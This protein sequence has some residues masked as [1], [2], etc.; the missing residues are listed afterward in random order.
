MPDISISDLGNILPSGSSVIPISNG[1]VTGKATIA[2]LQV[3]YSNLTNKPTIPTPGGIPVGTTA[4]RPTSP[5]LGTMRFNTTN[6]ALEWWSGEAWISISR[7]LTPTNRTVITSSTTYNR[8]NSNASEL[9]VTVVGGGG[10]GGSGYCSCPG[11]NGGF[12]GIAYVVIPN[13]GSSYAVTVG[14]G[15]F[16]AQSSGQ[17]YN[18]GVNGGPGGASSFGSIVAGGGAAG[19]RAA[20]YAR[21]ADGSC[22]GPTTTCTTGQAYNISGTLYG[23]SG[24]GG[25]QNSNCEYSNSAQSA[26]SQGVVVVE[27]YVLGITIN[28]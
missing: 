18:T 3:D 5:S 23:N 1:A 13:P 10:G 12:G 6:N 21:S 4:E 8:I 26:G 15:G 27:E 11:G 16:A 28:V 7:P 19:V 20:C 24:I 22:S 9:R 25:T 14:G 2:S 17:R